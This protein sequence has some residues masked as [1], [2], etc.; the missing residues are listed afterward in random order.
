MGRTQELEPHQQAA[1]LALAKRYEPGEAKTT[2][3]GHPEPG[4][5]QVAAFMDTAEPC[6]YSVYT[7]TVLA[8][9]DAL[10]CWARGSGN[11]YWCA[12]CSL[13]CI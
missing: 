5:P 4:V 1:V 9:I 12:P 11:E 7:A 6:L 3:F 13:L 8:A 10:L 2:S